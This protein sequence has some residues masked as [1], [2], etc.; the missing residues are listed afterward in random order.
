MNSSFSPCEPGAA[1]GSWAL[2]AVLVVLAACLGSGGVNM[3]RLYWRSRAQGDNEFCPGAGIWVVG[4]GC[5]GGAA[6]CNFF[7]L[8]FLPQSSAAAFGAVGVL[9]NLAVAPW[10]N[11]EKLP[12]RVLVGTGGVAAGC[13]LSGASATHRTWVCGVEALFERY[14]RAEFAFYECAICVL[15]LGGAYAAWCDDRGKVALPMLAGVSGAQTALFAKGAAEIAVASLEGGGSPFLWIGPP[16][17][18]VVA[19]LVASTLLYLLTLNLALARL[20]ALYVVPV[21]M[22]FWL[23]ATS[24]GGVVVYEDLRDLNPGRAALFAAG[25]VLCCAGV[26]LLVPRK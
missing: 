11:G 24:A 7:A 23:G 26:L 22:A 14:A 18:L 13:L 19:A 25:L 16:V 1:P 4:L 15:M 5:M 21:S 12:R 20:P 9:S 17:A 8:L 6:L 10:M 2:G 3:K